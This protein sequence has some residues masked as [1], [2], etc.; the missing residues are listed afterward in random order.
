MASRFTSEKE[1]NKEDT[2][3]LSFPI[4]GLVLLVLFLL[5]LLHDQTIQHLMKL[6][7]EN[8][9]LQVLMYLGIIFLLVKEG[10]WIQKLLV[11]ICE[12]FH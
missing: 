1:K 10:E 4:V 11:K 7:L 9:Y 2:K 8:E 6:E 12:L 3:E 5:S